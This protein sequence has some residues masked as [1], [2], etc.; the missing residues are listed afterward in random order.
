MRSKIGVAVAATLC[1]AVALV[2]PASAAFPGANGKIAFESSRSIHTVNPDGTGETTIA[3]RIAE[4]PAWSADGRRIA[5]DTGRGTISVANADGTGARNIGA[6]GFAAN[7]AWSPDGRIAY[8]SSHEQC[9]PDACG[10]VP[11]G[12]FVIN[13]DGSGDHQLTTH[14]AEPAWSPDG[15]KI[16]FTDYTSGPDSSTDIFVMDAEGGGITNLTRTDN[17]YEASPDW[18]PD[19]SRIAF[20]RQ[21]R[22]S[23][24]YDIYAINAD[25]TG[26]TR[27]TDDSARNYREGA[28]AWSP[29]GSKVLFESNRTSY[30]G[31]TCPCTSLVIVVMDASGANQTDIIG[32]ERPDWQP[33]PGPQ[34]SDYRNAAQ[35]CKAERSFLGDAAF[36][37][38]YGGGANAYGKCVSAK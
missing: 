5:Y 2:A 24:F 16:A 8:D 29:D 38:K 19:G 27:L 6:T 15:A 3:N 25:G 28:P 31:P 20:V 7:P 34:R 32:G 23:S 10:F 22:F 26:L 4:A 13:S 18:S 12:I 9:F 35:F 17:G 37:K 30:V 14:G 21:E 36:T 1:W 11:D 33:I